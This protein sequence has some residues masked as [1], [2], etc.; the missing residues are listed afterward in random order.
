MHSTKIFRNGKSQVVRIPA[1][2]SYDR[3]DVEMQI[4]RIGDELR[5]RPVRRSLSG[6]MERFARFY[7]SLWQKVVASMTNVSEMRSDASL[8]APNIQPPNLDRVLSAL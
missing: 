8:H 2:F 7:Q 5:I 1:E 6:L 4:E 3:T